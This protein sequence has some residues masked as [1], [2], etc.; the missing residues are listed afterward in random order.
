VRVDAKQ[1][2]DRGNGIGVRVREGNAGLPLLGAG[3]AP[4][5]DVRARQP[6]ASGTNI[7]LSVVPAG[8]NAVT[9]VITPPPAASRTLGP[10]TT[11]DQI[12]SG[13]ASDPDVLAVAQGTVLP[14]ASGSTPLS[15]RVN[16]D[17]LNEG[18]DL[19]PYS[20]LADTASIANINDP[21]VTLSVV[22]AAPTLP[23]AI[24]GVGLR[25]GRDPGPALLLNPDAG[26]NPLVEITPL[27]AG[28]NVA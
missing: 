19:V 12:V 9:L 16:I 20:D 25:A 18:V 17:V 23:D 26:T 10:F 5:V 2:G 14:A 24:D 13:L 22:N 28:T 21:T 1:T 8:P 6:G 15:R 11:V 3:N 7:R 27:N 4:S